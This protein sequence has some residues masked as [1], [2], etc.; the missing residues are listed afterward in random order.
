MRK[1]ADQR[2]ADITT[3]RTSVVQPHQSKKTASTSAGKNKGEQISKQAR[4]LAMLRAPAG[5]TIAAV[6]KATGWQQHSVRG[7]FSEWCVR[8]SA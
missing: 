1:I 4:M 7:F 8:S 2:A 6:M 5:A 3:T